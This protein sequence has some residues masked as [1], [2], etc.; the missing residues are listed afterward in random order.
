MLFLV[1]RHI[2]FVA[3]AIVILKLVIANCW[4]LPLGNYL[5][6]TVEC[7]RRIFVPM[8]APS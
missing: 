8:G 6:E 5:L 7:L 2:V 4:V 3:D 1:E